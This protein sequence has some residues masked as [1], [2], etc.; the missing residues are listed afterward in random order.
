MMEGMG[1]LRFSGIMFLGRLQVDVVAGGITWNKLYG[2]LFLN[3]SM[4]ILLCM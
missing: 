2:L 3:T 4:D 1:I